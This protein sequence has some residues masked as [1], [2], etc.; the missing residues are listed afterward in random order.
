MQ[1]KHNI[2]KLYL[3]RGFLWFMVAM[4]IIVLFFKKNGLSLF[5]VMILQSVYSLT[6]AITEIPSGYIADYFGRRKSII[7]STIFTF[8]G[9]LIFSNFA[10]F[11][12]FVIAQI[13]VAI[14]GSLMSGADSAI[15][16]D[17][18]LETENEKQYTR[19]EGKTYAIGNFSEAIAGLIGGVLATSSLLLP[20]QIQTTILFFTIPIAFSLVEPTLHK[21]DKIEKGFYSILKVVK[22]SL[23]ENLKLRWLIIYSS[24]MGVATLSAAWLAQPFFESL[25]IPLFY[26]GVLWAAL[27]ITA[28]ISSYSSHKTEEKHNT[29]NLLLKLGVF[30]SI[31]F[32]LV[33]FSP[34]YFGLIFIFIIYYLRGIVTPLLK[35]KIN[36]NTTSKIRATVMSVRS[37][38]LRISFAIV[39]PILGIMA[40]NKSIISSYL[41]LSIVILIFS[42]ISV[43]GLKKNTTQKLS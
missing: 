28:G 24:I 17:T 4:P 29:N 35:N 14:G 21:N 26:Y 13:L 7:F 5:E 42:S 31:S 32:L 37:F 12:Y 16:Y 9:Y 30:M 2:L 23:F 27:N 36:I 22:Y 3:L 6:V 38:V 40:D 33:Y 43:I 10:G 18:L 11:D 25:E 41:F 1:L 8:S 19:I 34:N 39:A 20:V 15:I